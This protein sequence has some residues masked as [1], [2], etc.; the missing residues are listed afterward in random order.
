MTDNL[1]FGMQATDSFYSI[2]QKAKNVP[3][4]LIAI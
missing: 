3:M 2:K 4:N 1:L